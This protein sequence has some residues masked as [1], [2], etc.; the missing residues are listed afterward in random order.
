MFR[1]WLHKAVEKGREEL[2]NSFTGF[3]V[4]D[5]G[6]EILKGSGHFIRRL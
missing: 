3:L 2:L 6:E 5:F 1:T 4:V